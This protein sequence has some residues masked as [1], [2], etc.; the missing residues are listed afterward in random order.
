MSVDDRIGHF[1][2]KVN[3]H[4][5]DADQLYDLQKDPEENDNIFEDRPEIAE[6][7]KAELSKALKSVGQG[8]WHAAGFVLE[9]RTHDVRVVVEAR[10]MKRR[11]ATAIRSRDAHAAGFQFK[12]L[13]HDGQVA[14]EARAV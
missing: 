13:T 8:Q 5:F 2:S 1:A 12:Q 7:M 3:P 11:D 14:T 6:R 9:K 10:A 4:Y